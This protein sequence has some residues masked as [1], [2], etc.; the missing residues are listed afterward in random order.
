MFIALFFLQQHGSLFLGMT[1]QLLSH[2]VVDW[3]KWLSLSVFRYYYGCL[4]YMA[5]SFSLFLVYYYVMMRQ[6]SMAFW[7]KEQTTLPLSLFSA[8]TGCLFIGFD[9]VTIKNNQQSGGQKSAVANNPLLTI[10]RQSIFWLSLGQ[11]CSS[12]IEWKELDCGWSVSLFSGIPTCYA[13]AKKP[14]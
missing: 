14:Q 4:E 12:C 11:V 6:L 3:S 10:C 5:L 7:L 8:Y 9:K 13:L 2:L 1:T